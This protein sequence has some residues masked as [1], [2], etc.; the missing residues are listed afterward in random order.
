MQQTYCSIALA[1]LPL[2][3]SPPWRSGRMTPSRHHSGPGGG[4]HYD[5]AVV[6]GGVAAAI[7]ALQLATSWQGEVR[8][9]GRGGEPRD[10]GGD[11]PTRI[12]ADGSLTAHGG[13]DVISN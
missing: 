2:W 13:Q 7:G 6:G 12:W 9:M 3:H 5:V 8:R 10:T 1:I 4:D 11:D